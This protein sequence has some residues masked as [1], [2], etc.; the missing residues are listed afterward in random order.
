MLEGI[1]T[2][3]A[4]RELLG[5]LYSNPDTRFYIRQLERLTGLPVN[6]VRRELSKLEK[7]GFLNSEEEGRVKYFK[8]NKKNPVYEDLRNIVLK[9]QVIGDSLRKLLVKISEIKV[10]FIYGSVAKSEETA[11]SDIDLMIIGKIDSVI[12]HKEINKIEDKI[13]RTINYTLINEKE[14]KNRKTDFIKRIAK[15]EKIFLIGDEDEL[16]RLG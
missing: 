7:F 12:L 16:E 2:S 5:I 9:T 10:A 6:A 1:I 15:E 3:K 14:F 4:T 8:V 13:K 11:I